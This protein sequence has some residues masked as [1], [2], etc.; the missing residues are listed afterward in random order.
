[1]RA[2]RLV[3]E[4]EDTGIGIAKDQQDLIFGAFNQVSGKS[5]R[6]FGGGAG[7]DDYRRL[8]DMMRGTITLQSEL[9]KGVRFGW[10]SQKFP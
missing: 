10:S 1:M 9:G 3:L 4:V 2:V 8:V 6:K 5:A 7:I